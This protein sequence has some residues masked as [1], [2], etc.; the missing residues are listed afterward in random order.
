[1]SPKYLSLVHTEQLTEDKKPAQ[2]SSVHPL[3]HHPL[4]LL[5]EPLTLAPVTTGGGLRTEPAHT[6]RTGGSEQ[7]RET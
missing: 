5:L 7:L 3:L 4:L 6:A 1:M 2:A